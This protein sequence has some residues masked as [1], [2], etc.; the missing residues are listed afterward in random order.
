MSPTR[1]LRRIGATG[2]VVYSQPMRAAVA[3]AVGAIS[4]LVLVATA[5]A[6]APTLT[7]V[8]VQ[9]RHPI[10]TFS[11]PR[12]EFAR[13]DVATRPARAPDGSFLNENLEVSDFLTASEIQSG[14][15][16][17]E[18]QLAPGT[19]H[20]MLLALPDA[21]SCLISDEGDY[22]PSCA[23]GYSAVLP[24]TVPRPP[25]RYTASARVRRSLQRVDLGFRVTPLGDQLRYRVCYALA[26]EQ[27]RCLAGAVEGFDWNSGATDVLSLSTRR[28][29][30]LATFTWL[31][32]G[33]AVAVK[34]VRT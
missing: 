17:H 13:I 9:D 6:V 16:A 2:Q 19:Y 22:D 12:A 5:L 30:T 24:L 26:N 4:A 34:R 23:D 8:A 25:A 27:R 18:E 32:G 31:V 7:S 28:L 15:W 14:R 10:A 3:L 21:D 1:G 33:R 29:P 20:V 11:A